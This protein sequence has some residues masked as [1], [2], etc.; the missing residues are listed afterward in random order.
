MTPNASSQSGFSLAETLV[1][2]F[3]LA[4][5]SSAGAS[6]LIGATGAGQQVRDRE[7]EARQIDIAQRLIRQDIAALSARAIQ[8]DDGFSPAANL[9]GEAPR[10]EDPFLTFVRS[11]WINP[12]R[13]E[14]RGSLQS[15]A[16]SLRQ[17]QLVRE[18]AL[19]PDATRSTPTISRVLL[20][21]V[22]AVEIGFFRGGDR[23]EFWRGDVLQNRSILPD[24]IELGITFEDDTTLRLA[25][26][27]GGRS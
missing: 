23:S 15:V 26:I 5:V 17:G 22:R 9:I 13:L 24:I 14:A 10:G 11:G 21:D 7:A 16:Y 2:L 6:L 3:I 8:P 12:G 20:E 27:T 4:L 1:A 19:R 25:A 18:V